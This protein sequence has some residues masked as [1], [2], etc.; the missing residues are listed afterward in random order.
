MMR[1][2]AVIIMMVVLSL[3]ACIRD[4]I[5]TCPPMEI[6]VD[7][8]DKNYSNISEFEEIGIEAQKEDLPFKE[9]VGTIYYRLS[10]PEDCSDIEIKGPFQVKTDKQTFTLSFNPSIPHG[11]YE[12][13]VWGGLKNADCLS[14]N[15]D[16]LILHDDGNIGEDI[17]LAR[18][19]F[20]YDAWNNSGRLEME[21]VKGQLTI[22][23]EGLQSGDLEIETKINGVCSLVDYNFNYQ[24]TCGCS[25]TRNLHIGKDK[26]VALNLAPTA[27]GKKA[28]VG[29]VYRD[30]QD[31]EYKP[32]DVEIE[33]KRN[34]ITAIKYTYNP[35]IYDFTIYLLIDGKWEKYHDMEI[36]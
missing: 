35:D 32:E 9:Y 2:V 28:K 16:S 26:T 11:T 29:I 12:L 33:I 13:T 20:N 5:P 8:L 10:N 14:E 36:D 18:G 21:R 7:V 4:K 19:I 24:G 15:A 22:I 30:I 1:R 6:T 3:T 25:A 34:A 31:N 27:T 23:T 17:Y